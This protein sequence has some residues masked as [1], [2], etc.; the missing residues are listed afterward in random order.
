MAPEGAIPAHPP[1]AFRGKI[2]N[3]CFILPLVGRIRFHQYFDLRRIDPEIGSLSY[4]LV[5]KAAFIL[6]IDG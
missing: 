5:R 1:G 6:P 3:I 4:C 2:L